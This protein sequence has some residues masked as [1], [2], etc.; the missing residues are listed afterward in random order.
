MI[1]FNFYSPTNM[2]FGKDTH[3]Q[4]GEIISSYNFKNILLNMTIYVN[5]SIV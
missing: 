5:Y 1:N 2:I 3:H 4:V